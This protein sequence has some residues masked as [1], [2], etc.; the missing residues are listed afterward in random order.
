MK[1]FAVEFSEAVP[2]SSI[3]IVIQ[4]VYAGSTYNDTVISNIEVYE[5]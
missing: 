1:E 4:E 3:Q 5:K 2:A